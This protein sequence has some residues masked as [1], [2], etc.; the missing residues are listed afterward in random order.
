MM[1]SECLVNCYEEKS[2]TVAW[3]CTANI[4]LSISGSVVVTML[5]SGDVSAAAAAHC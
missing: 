2:S 5:M 3:T 4:V 1:K